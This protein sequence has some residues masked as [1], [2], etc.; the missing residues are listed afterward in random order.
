MEYVAIY[1]PFRSFSC[2]IQSAGMRAALRIY[3]RRF[4]AKLRADSKQYSEHCDANSFIGHV[5][6][7]DVRK[8]G[9]TNKT[10][11]NTIA[12]KLTYAPQGV[13]NQPDK[14]NILRVFSADKKDPSQFAV[15]PVQD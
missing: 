2:R 8:V 4:R 10:R 14:N 6:A 13:V 5:L 15:S 12:N 11:H 9:I 1:L 7:I 3:W